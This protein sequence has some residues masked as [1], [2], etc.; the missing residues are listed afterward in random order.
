[1]HSFEDAKVFL[2][3]FIFWRVTMRRLTFLGLIVFAAWPM[4]APSQAPAGVTVFEGA[5]IIVGDGQAPM[6]N[7]SFIVSGG[8]ITQVGRASDVRVPA[9]VTR[10]SLTGKTVMPAI[11]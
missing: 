9:G 7:A 3:E 2:I 4:A 5:R 10:V 11:I 6:E 8:R 1:M